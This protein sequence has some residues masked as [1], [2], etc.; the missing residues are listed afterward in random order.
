M[1]PS[2]RREY[3]DTVGAVRMSGTMVVMVVDRDRWRGMDR[4]VDGRRADS[5]AH[6]PPRR[7]R[8]AVVDPSADSGTGHVRNGADTTRSRLYSRVMILN[9]TV[10]NRSS[11]TPCEGDRAGRSSPSPVCR[12]PADPHHGRRGL[13][14][15]RLVTARYPHRRDD[16]TPRSPS[17]TARNASG[18]CGRDGWRRSC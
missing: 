6:S 4:R 8:G 11:S 16:R 1:I 18:C 17:R 9:V 3:R 10:R 5:R 13:A 14:F 7:H 12:G 15:R 2:G